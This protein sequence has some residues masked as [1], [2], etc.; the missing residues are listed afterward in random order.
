MNTIN[1]F[2]Q[3][4]QNAEFW[5]DRGCRL[6][7]TEQYEEAVA[8]LKRAI[9]LNPNYCQA[10]NNLAN[11]LSALKRYGSALGSY[12]KAVA[13]NPR[14]HQAWFNRGLLLAEMQAYG[15]ALESYERAIAIHPDPRYIHACENIRLKKK[16]FSTI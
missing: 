5:E 9:A 16:L 12:D 4:H 11:A 10:W 7:Q 13:L 8:A 1:T 6:C 2:D 15:N 14:Y 3:H